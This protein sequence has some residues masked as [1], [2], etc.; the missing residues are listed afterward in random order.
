MKCDLRYN[1]LFLEKSFKLRKH[2]APPM[3]GDTPKDSSV[4]KYRFF[5]RLFNKSVT[6]EELDIP[7][8]EEITEVKI[9]VLRDAELFKDC[10][11]RLKFGKYIRVFKIGQYLTHKD[12]WYNKI[13][14]GLS[15]LCEYDTWVRGFNL[16]VPT[17]EFIKQLREDMY[18]NL[19]TNFACN[20]CDNDFLKAPPECNTINYIFSKNYLVSKTSDVYKLIELQKALD[21]SN[22]LETLLIQ[23][24]L[25][26]SL[27]I[28]DVLKIKPNKCLLGIR[29]A[30]KIYEE[31]LTGGITL[32]D[33]LERVE[34]THTY[35]GGFGGFGESMTFSYVSKM[36][37]NDFKQFV[38]W[39]KTLS[40]MSMGVV[41][42][43]KPDE[44]HF[45]SE[46]N[47]SNLKKAKLFSG[48][49]WVILTLA[50]NFKGKMLDYLK[51][52]ISSLATYNHTIVHD[53]TYFLPLGGLSEGI[54]N[55]LMSHAETSSNVKEFVLKNWD[56][57]DFDKMTVQDINKLMHQ[58]ELNKE[59]DL[60][61]KSFPEVAKALQGDVAQNI[62]AGK[63]ISKSTGIE[64]EIL[65][66][67]DTTGLL[68]GS[69]SKCC[70]KLDGAGSSCVEA[71]YTHPDSSFAVFRKGTK[72]L[73]Q[74]WIWSDKDALVFDNFEAP[75]RINQE[76]AE[77]LFEDM[78]NSF[79]MWNG[80]ICLGT[81]LSDIHIPDSIRVEVNKYKLEGY[82][83]YSDAKCVAF[84]RE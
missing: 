38:K 51:G 12:R 14:G 34:Y 71:G 13:S 17:A 21:W 54:V 11:V 29:K 37:N 60:V 2:N 47:M 45:L 15:L 70:Q 30:T 61:N 77:P 82:T 43:I 46:L 72:F 33:M 25:H 69:L 57:Y 1:T 59:I 65:K 35:W 39:G 63:W 84:I 41:N 6:L 55:W 40:S 28:F 52:S 23:K 80:K 26:S 19:K 73:G 16:D 9:R 75:F 48:D 36:S 58:M 49:M 44:W 4:T 22:N 3:C 83:G 68:L 24:A 50:L 74:S 10:T 53:A 8:K 42:I 67:T 64:V 79:D 56:D 32:N 78:C 5:S 62:P 76:T 66:K 20:L 31:T 7:E 18:T 27:P 81:G